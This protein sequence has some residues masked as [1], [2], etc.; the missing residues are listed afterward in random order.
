MESDFI[1]YTATTAL[2]EGKVL[3]LAPH[4]DDEVFGC[5]GAIIQH[6]VQ[7]D[8]VKVIVLTDGSAATNHSDTKSRLRYIEIR[9]QESYQAAKILGYGI[10]E[11]WGIVDRTLSYDETLIQRLCDSIQTHKIT[12]VYAPSLQEIHPDHNILAN[13][14][15]EA[16]R[17]CKVT[18]IMYEVGIP[19]RPNILLDITHYLNQKK[20]AMSC[21]ASQLKIQDY[22]R[23]ILCLNG[24]RSYTLPPQVT[25]AE[26]YYRFDNDYPAL[27]ITP[28]QLIQDFTRLN[29][30]LDR[31]YKSY[32]W[33][34]TAPLRWL[35]LLSKSIIYKFKF[36]KRQ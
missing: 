2:P 19:L 31:I 29:Q 25:E 18:L 35:K 14:A 33:R 4:P 8:S 11:F 20:Q 1:P 26:A 23:H 22:R 5:A 13:L 34:L 10:P 27:A 16:T 17:R 24:Y 6:I 32:S 7:G 28:S 21:F 9:Q 12:Q 3:V 30:E 36:K 15:V